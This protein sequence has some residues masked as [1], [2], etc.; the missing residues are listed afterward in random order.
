MPRFGALW[1]R[2]GI[3][4]A[5]ALRAEIRSVMGTAQGQMV[6]VAS[7]EVGETKAGPL[8]IIAH[9]ADLKTADGR[10]GRDFLEQFTVTIDAKGRLVTLVPI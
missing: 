6:Q 8:R 10:L 9:D 4:A 7:L 3:A 2:L 1:W 5:D